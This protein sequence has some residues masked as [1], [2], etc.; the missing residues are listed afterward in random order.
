MKE[1]LCVVLLMASLAASYGDDRPAKPSTEM[2]GLIRSV[3]LELLKLKPSIPWLAEYDA[4]CLWQS[5]G[6]NLIQYSP[7]EKEEKGPQPQQ[8]DHFSLSYIELDKTTGPKY[9][10]TFEGVAACRFPELHLKIYGE[11]LVWRDRQLEKRLAQVV[12]AKCK[13]WPRPR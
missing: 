9:S 7:K 10:N 2:N 1:F 5:E 12:I 6:R 4:S 13:E 8:S 3:H 11:V